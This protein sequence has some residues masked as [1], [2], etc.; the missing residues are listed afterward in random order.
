MTEVR[1]PPGQAF[2]QGVTAGGR[3]GQRAKAVEDVALRA[4]QLFQVLAELGRLAGGASAME[5]RPFQVDGAE[6][7]IIKT[8]ILGNL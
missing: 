1:C 4:V 6:E 3:S 5:N 8:S 2:D 7:R